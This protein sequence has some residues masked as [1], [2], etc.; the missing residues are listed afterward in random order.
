MENSSENAF[1]NFPKVLQL[2][3]PFKQFFYV[4][5]KVLLGKKEDLNLYYLLHQGSFSLR[6]PCLM[7]SHPTYEIFAASL[8]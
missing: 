5:Q 2:T 7:I 8:I 6:S 4:C 1:D 3:T